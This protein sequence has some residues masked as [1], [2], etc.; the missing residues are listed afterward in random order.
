MHM[1]KLLR[2]SIIKEFENKTIDYENLPSKFMMDSVIRTTNLVSGWLL[3]MDWS[4]LIAPA[5]CSFITSDSPVVVR[6]P[7]DPSWLFCGFASSLKIQL[8]FPLTPKICL[9]GAWGRLRRVIEYIDKSEVR[10][11]NFETY[12]Y[13]YRYLYSSSKEFAKEILYVNNMVNKGLIK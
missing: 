7:D 2:M 5:D 12:K 13:S 6:N 3:R 10:E 11:L 8:H 4:L 1:K 9:Y